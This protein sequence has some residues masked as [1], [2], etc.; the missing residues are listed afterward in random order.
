MCNT[1]AC[2]SF[3]SHDDW[4]IRKSENNML[5]PP[6]PPPGGAVSTDG[7]R[8][9]TSHVF[10]PHKTTSCTHKFQSATHEMHHAGFMVLALSHCHDANRAPSA[11]SP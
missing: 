4:A 7:W 8:E 11:I 2:C 1:V 3:A 9:R 5:H 10:E 6:L